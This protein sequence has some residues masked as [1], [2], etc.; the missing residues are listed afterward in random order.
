MTV[1]SF[2]D[3]DLCIMVSDFLSFCNEYFKL[4]YN[5]RAGSCNAAFHRILI[6]DVGTCKYSAF[7]DE[8]VLS[9]NICKE[10]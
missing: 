5:R 4:I 2:Y 9:Y 7:F 6:R 1:V 8:A 10:V 3:H